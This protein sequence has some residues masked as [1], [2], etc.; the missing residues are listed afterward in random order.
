MPVGAPFM[1]ALV[2]GLQITDT[3]AVE[4]FGLK[5]RGRSG[6]SSLKPS[7]SW[8]PD[9]PTPPES[10]VFPM[11]MIQRRVTARKITLLRI[12]YAP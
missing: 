2:I 12:R 10:K 8:G 4:Y 7:Y 3:I 6:L 9:S 5:Q 11:A 1:G